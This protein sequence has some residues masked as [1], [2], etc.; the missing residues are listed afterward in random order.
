MAREVGA[1]TM[2]ARLT[3]P[4]A[5]LM[6]SLGLM[7]CAG[8]DPVYRPA[9]KFPAQPPVSPMATVAR[10]AA[11]LG[12]VQGWRDHMTY[13]PSIGPSL[14]CKYRDNRG[15][16]AVR[17]WRAPDD[18]VVLTMN[19]DTGPIPVTWTIN[20]QTR[21]EQPAYLWNLYSAVTWSAAYLYQLSFVSP[22]APGYFETEAKKYREA[23]TKPE[24]P[25]SAREFKV[26]AESAVKEKRFLDAVEAYDQALQIAPWWPQ[27]H[28][29]AALILAEL[30]VYGLAVDEMQR[31]LLLAPDAA[32]AR[33]A[34]DKIYDWKGKF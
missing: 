11:A 27:G 17:N 28:F 9:D 12:N 1:M 26:R 29:N 31:Y 3:L 19:C 15:A 34:Q 22:E 2:S 8:T 23:E 33:Q 4:A 24:L 5:A 6:V 18:Y 30:K 13:K 16:H 21:V 14:S 20:T 10:L 32:N 7:G 25:E